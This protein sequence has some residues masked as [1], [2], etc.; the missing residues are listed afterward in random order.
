VLNVIFRLQLLMYFAAKLKHK[1]SSILMKKSLIVPTFLIML[2]CLLL[3]LPFIIRAAVKNEFETRIYDPPAA[4]ES[5]AALVFGAAVRPGGYLSTALRDRMD[6]AIKLYDIGAVTTLVVSGH[7]DGNGYDEPG[8]MKAYAEAKGVSAAD[9]IVDLYGNRTFDTCYR[10]IKQFNLNSVLLVTQEF[11]LPR[12]LL[13][14]RSLGLDAAGVRA[15]Q[16]SY[17][18][19][20]WYEFRETF[21]TLVAFADLLRINRSDHKEKG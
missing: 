2:A 6:T 18:G 21:A 13:T 1:L 4:P 20:S 7:R 15:D 8:S 10:A 14:C 5:E 19:S 3:T 17:R 11:H 12:A 16:H 9:I